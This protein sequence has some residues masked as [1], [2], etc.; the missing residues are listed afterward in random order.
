MDEYLAMW[1]TKQR[2]RDNEE[3][4]ARYALAREARAAR[5]PVRAVIGL[6]LIR[7]GRFLV[8]GTPAWA[9]QPRG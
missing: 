7:V 2:L 9:G 8:R 5:P 6:A 1:L 4:V 3:L